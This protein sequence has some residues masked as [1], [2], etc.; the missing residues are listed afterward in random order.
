MLAIFACLQ[1]ANEGIRGRTQQWKYIYANTP[2]WF[3]IGTLVIAGYAILWAAVDVVRRHG[4]LGRSRED[5][6]MGVLTATMMFSY[7]VIGGTFVG[8]QLARTPRRVV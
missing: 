3:R 8:T 4:D 5:A 6:P 1:L 7:V 2:S